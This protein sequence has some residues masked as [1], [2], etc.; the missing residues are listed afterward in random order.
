MQLNFVEAEKNVF[1][2]EY[3]KFNSTTH[4]MRFDNDDDDVRKNV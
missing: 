3:W 4:L 2:R 1:V